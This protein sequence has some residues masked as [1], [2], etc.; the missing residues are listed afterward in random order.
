M[1]VQ[2]TGEFGIAQRRLPAPRQPQRDRGDHVAIPAGLLEQ[3]VPIAEGAIAQAQRDEVAGLPVP[4]AQAVEAFAQLDAVGADVLNGRRA[5]AAGDQRQVFEAGHAVGDGPIDGRVPVLAGTHR[6]QPGVV[7][8]GD[9]VARNLHQQHH[10]IEIAGQHHVAAAAQHDHRPLRGAGV[11]E[12]LDE[13][14]FAAHRHRVACAY[15]ETQ[16]VVLAQRIKFVEICHA[17]KVAGRG[18]PN[19]GMERNG[20]DCR[21]GWIIRNHRRGPARFRDRTGYR[22]PRY[23]NTEGVGDAVV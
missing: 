7:G 6:H 1:I 2:L 17:E 15:V 9:G 11:G 8:G 19:S 18:C 16:C 10:R 22:G 23:R 4:S 5:H 21:V 3:A 20:L 13:V 14:A 12:C